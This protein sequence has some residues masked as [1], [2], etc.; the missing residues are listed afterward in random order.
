MSVSEAE[1]HVAQPVTGI[2]MTSS[3]TAYRRA[4]ALSP[5]VEVYQTTLSELEQFMSANR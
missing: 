4:I 2:L 3:I 5:S 1:P